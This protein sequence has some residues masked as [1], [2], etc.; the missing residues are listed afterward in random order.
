L[1]YTGRVN[2]ERIKDH[3]QREIKELDLENEDEKKELVRNGDLIHVAPVSPRFDKVVTLAGHVAVPKRVNW[4]DGMRITDL[5][6]SRADLIPFS[7][8]TSKNELVDG[9]VGEEGE[10][11]LPSQEGGEISGEGSRTFRL[12]SKQVR[13]F[14]HLELLRGARKLLA[15]V[16]WE[17]ATVMRIDPETLENI[18]ITFNLGYALRQNDPEHNLLLRVGDV[19]TTYARDDIRL[20]KSKRQEFVS[21]E[22]EVNNP[23]L[24][25][26]SP[27]ET[28]KDLINRANG[29]TSE[30]YVYA[31]VFS[32]ASVREAQQKRM[33]EGLERLEK[34]V[35]RA[36]IR[37]RAETISSDLKESYAAQVEA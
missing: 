20:P 2:I 24:Y 32:R 36:S 27:G 10:I 12:N 19:V 9:V 3:K 22:G 15:E 23:G 35:E 26:I 4:K 33:D 5:I 21:I 17:Y 25:E 31:S 28:L 18:F 13:E 14:R 11:S 34:E 8:W 29:F 30:A 6:P 16:N 7:Y 37:L 1:A